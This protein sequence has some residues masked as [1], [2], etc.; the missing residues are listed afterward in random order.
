MSNSGLFSSLMH[1]FRQLPPLL[2]SLPLIP[3]TLITFVVPGPC[4]WMG[5]GLKRAFGNCSTGHCLEA[6][7]ETGGIVM[8]K[9]VDNVCCWKEHGMFVAFLELSHLSI[10]D[11]YSLIMLVSL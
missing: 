4:T 5:L 11:L 1:A 6:Q 2:K 9:E 3:P 7:R 8:L 10:G